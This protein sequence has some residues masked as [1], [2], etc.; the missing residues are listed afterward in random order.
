MCGAILDE[1]QVDTTNQKAMKEDPTLP[2]GTIYHMAVVPGAMTPMAE[3]HYQEEHSLL[4]HGH[5]WEEV[6]EY[7][8]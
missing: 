3:T 4:W 6:R 5:W 8:W 1:E 2:P 7:Y